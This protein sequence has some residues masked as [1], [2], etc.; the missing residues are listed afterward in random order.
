MQSMDL[1]G[2][3][4]ENNLLRAAHAAGMVLPS[5]LAAQTKLRWSRSSRT[6]KGVHAASAVSAPLNAP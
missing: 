1:T 6:D 4:V 5:N 2:N 3:T